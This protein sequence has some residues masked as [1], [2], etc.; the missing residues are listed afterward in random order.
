MQDFIDKK[1]KENLIIKYAINK[2]LKLY[3]KHKIPGPVKGSEAPYSLEGIIKEYNEGFI[4][5]GCLKNENAYFDGT[6]NNMMYQLI[7][8]DDIITIKFEG[9]YF[10][11]PEYFI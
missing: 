3:L 8:T 2:K 7:N 1:N 10:E 4:L 11:K 9:F 6:P 5:F